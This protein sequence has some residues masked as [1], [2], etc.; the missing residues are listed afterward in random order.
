[1]CPNPPRVIANFT[2]DLSDGVVLANLIQ[3]HAPFLAL[4]YTQQ[5]QAEVSGNLAAVAAALRNLCLDFV[6]TEQD[7]ARPDHREML[8]FVALLSQSLPQY[9]AQ[10]TI[11]FVSRLNEPVVKCI[12]LTN[13]SKKV[14]AY[15]VKLE[16]ATEFKI[17][18]TVIQLEPRLTTSVPIE[19]TA[20]F[21]K[22]YEATLIL[23]SKSQ[24]GVSSCGPAGVPAGLDPGPAR[25]AHLGID[26]LPALPEHPLRDQGSQPVHRG[27][28]L[29]ISIIRDKPDDSTVPKTEKRRLKS[30]TAAP[31]DVDVF[32]TEQTRLSLAAGATGTLVVLFSPLQLGAQRGRIL[33][34]DPRVGEFVVAIDGV[35]ELPQ[36]TETVTITAAGETTHYIGVPCRNKLL[37]LCKAEKKHVARAF[38][39]CMPPPSE[40]VTYKVEVSSPFYTAPAEFMLQPAVAP[41]R[42]CPAVPVRSLRAL[43]ARHC[44]F[45]VLHSPCHPAVV[46]ASPQGGAVTRRDAPENELNKVPINFHPK[47]PGEYPCK[48]V[49]RSLWDVRV[50]ALRGLCQVRRAA[51]CITRLPAPNCHISGH[52]HG[53][54]P[55]YASST[56]SGSVA[57]LEFVTAARQAITQEI[58]M[59]NPTKQDWLIKATLTGDPFK[60]PRELRVP[61]GG[62]ATYALVFAP[63]IIGEYTGELTLSN[64][65]AGPETPVRQDDLSATGRGEAPAAEESFVIE[66]QARHKYTHTLQVPHLGGTP[67]TPLTYRV[68]TDLPYVTGSPTLTVT[69]P[70]T[71]YTLEV[72]PPRSLTATGTLM[73][74]AP[75]GQY[76]WYSGEIRAAPPAVEQVIPIATRVRQ[77]VAIQVTVMNPLDRQGRGLVGATSFA[78][79]PNEQ[80]L[81]ELVYAPLFATRGPVQHASWT[82]PATGQETEVAF[83]EEGLLAFRSEAGEFWYRLLLTCEP[84]PPAE[85][86]PM[87]SE[88]GLTAVQR[89]TIENPTG[90]T[91]KLRPHSSNPLAFTIGPASSPITP[92]LASS[93]ASLRPQSAS[94]AGAVTL[95]PYEQAEALVR[96]SPTTLGVEESA[97]LTVSSPEAGE[98]VFIAK[99]VGLAPTVMPP[100][101][102][103]AP[104]RESSS[105]VLHFRNPFGT[106]V[107]AD[108]AVEID[109]SEADPL[110]PGADP[111]PKPLFSI[112]AKKT[113]QIPVPPRQMLQVGVLF[114]PHRLLTATARLLVRAV[115]VTTNP[116]PPPPPGADPLPGLSPSPTLEPPEPA[117][118]ALAAEPEEGRALTWTQPLIG[119]AEMA[120]TS[121]PAVSVRGTAVVSPPSPAR[122]AISGNSPRPSVM[123]AATGSPPQPATQR[124]SAAAASAAMGGGSA[125]VLLRCV[126]HER[127]ARTVNVP[128]VSLTPAL[129]AAKKWQR[130]LQHL[131]AQI[132]CSLKADDERALAALRLGAPHPHLAAEEQAGPPAEG[133]L[134]PSLAVDLDFAP[135]LPIPR[136]RADLILTRQP[137]A[138]GGRWRFA[139]YVQALAGSPQPEDEIKLSAAVGGQAS[140]TLEIRSA[141]HV[142]SPFEAG[143]QPGSAPEFTISPKEGLFDGMGIARVT[144]TFTPTR[145]GGDRRGMVAVHTQDMQ[146][147]FGLVGTLPPYV[148]PHSD[149]KVLTRRAPGPSAPG[150]R[151]GASTAGSVAATRQATPTTAAGGLRQSTTAGARPR[152]STVSTPARPVGTSAAAASGTPG[153]T[154]RGSRVGAS[155]GA[156]LGSS[157]T[158][159]RAGGGVIKGGGAALL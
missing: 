132:T 1:M 120:F 107:L 136:C 45:Q 102:I 135:D 153:T 105:A 72:N 143:L 87:Q 56:S 60:G 22:P 124:P 40:P 147:L 55:L 108:L 9:A 128:L 10:T 65:S 38:A 18:Q 94:G 83:G 113:R 68:E 32:T 74:V 13:P 95:G 79:Q 6:P 89:V 67:E 90:R 12:E 144:L 64:P 106:A 23:S 140:H 26:K 70:T 66:C 122:T 148:A 84:A 112:L 46:S 96:Y 98:W 29:N 157:G 39:K 117:V 101:T 127:V 43:R 31:L 71:P 59:A 16:G 28:D 118:P 17:A 159:G 151:G 78:L 142:N 123:T 4:K 50:F 75:D 155:R 41:T 139:V 145:Y 93:T 111:A 115:P 36:P 76:L 53:D 121:I 97:T 52:G 62:S 14:L 27:V 119:L 69:S 63:K 156:V 149:P 30:F 158:G 126:A 5:N 51:P 137:E 130:L 99:G 21:N 114:S 125:Q 19:L 57:Q 15:A 47:S 80:R 42:V 146:W 73:F 104:V 35:G 154:L 77:A 85:L 110:Q 7:M 88:L 44:P 116:F 103:V 91:I 20:Y 86:A 133:A 152:V 49:L 81:Y 61:A 33:L 141:S 48:L 34:A 138:G 100:V 150:T 131:G 8:L 92:A 109:P 2:S 54:L 3:S 134:T 129:T 37:E 82:D 25:A 11:D 24:G 58:P